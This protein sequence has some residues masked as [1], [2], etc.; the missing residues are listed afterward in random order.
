MLTARLTVALLGSAFLNLNMTTCRSPGEADKTPEKKAETQAAHVTLPG[1][2]TSELSPRE[3][4]RWSAHVS[5][6]LAPCEDTPVSIAKCIEEKRNCSACLPAAEYLLNQ[7]REGKTQSQVDAA[8]KARFSAQSVIEIDTTG[9][10]SKGAPDAA[11]TIV[12]WAD[13]EC[14]ACRNA[15]PVLDE[16][17]KENKDLRLVFK[18]YPLDAHPNAELAAR[19]S[20]AADLQGKFWEMHHALFASQMP[21]VEAT[22]LQIARDL[23]LDEERFKTDMRSEKIAD[24]VAQDRKQGVEVKLRATPTIFVNGRLFDYAADMKTGF[25]DWIALERKLIGSQ[26]TSPSKSAPAAPAQPA[27]KAP[28]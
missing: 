12:E 23:K 21:L 28:Q 16:L 25:N 2:D 19:A 17:I 26:P 18:N 24:R 13:F 8:Y 14:P 7:V 22:L 15:S 1:V 4:S 3:E 10:P 5:E 9:S 6:L 11:I 20:L 27:S